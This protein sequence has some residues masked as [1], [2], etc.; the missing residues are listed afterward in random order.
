MPG[1]EANRMIKGTDSNLDVHITLHQHFRQCSLVFLFKCYCRG[2][3]SS[4]TTTVLEIATHVPLYLKNV[5]LQHRN[6]PILLCQ[7]HQTVLLS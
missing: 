3:N 6:I 1:S 5:M 7:H 4:L 2:H